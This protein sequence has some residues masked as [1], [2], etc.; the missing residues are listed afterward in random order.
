MD[1]VT[2]DQ[3][4]GFA[5]QFSALDSTNQSL[6]VTAASRLFDNLCEVAEDFFAPYVPASPEVFTDRDFYG[7]DTAYLQIDPFTELNGT[8]PVVIDTDPDVTYDLPEYSVVGD[9]LVVLDRTR[10]MRE[11]AAAYPFRFVGWRRGVKVT[12]SAK[13]GWAE[14]PADVQMAVIAIAINQFR[15]TDPAFTK[16]SDVEV[17]DIPPIAQTVVDK[18]RQRYSRRALFA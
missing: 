18:Y 16:L 6:L 4:E 1:Y 2:T 9:R 3:V 17:A 13:W 15:M 10:L 14:T 8:D 5:Q 7:D 12:V 11:E